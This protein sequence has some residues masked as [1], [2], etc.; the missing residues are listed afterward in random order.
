[1]SMRR[2]F[3]RRR[4]RSPSRRSV[5]GD[6][7]RRGNRTPGWELCIRMR[8]LPK[9]Q[10]GRCIRDDEPP[11]DISLLFRKREAVRTGSDTIVNS[12]L[13]RMDSSHRFGNLRRSVGSRRFC[14]ACSRGL[15]C[16]RAAGDGSPACCSSRTGFLRILGGM[17]TPVGGR[18]VGSRR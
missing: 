10:R 1:M 17:S 18:R 15:S 9:V 3:D 7:R 11:R 16:T 2:R 8:D 6:S 13:G 4:R 5:P 12:K 14:R